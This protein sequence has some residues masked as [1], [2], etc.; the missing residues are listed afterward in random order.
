MPGKKLQIKFT[1]VRKSGKGLQERMLFLRGAVKNIHQVGSILPS[2]QA[3]A[4]SM[5][6]MLRQQPAPRRILE[7]G[8]GTGPITAR[9]VREMKPGDHLDIYEIDP[10]FTAFLVE[11]FAREPNFQRVAHQVAI[12]TD[13]IEAIKPQAQYDIIISA[14]PFTNLPPDAVKLFFETYRTILRP[15]G[16]LTYIEFIFG[17][18]ILRVFARKDAR[19]RLRGVDNVVRRYVSAYEIKRQIVPF[20][21]PPARIR[22]LRFDE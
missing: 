20:N 7:V 3:V 11:R 14:V 17:R 9:I 8:A 15:D 1:K 18:T 2:S 13:S 5:T 21:A 12:H 6:Q 19:K 16:V 4:Q 22:S 10:K